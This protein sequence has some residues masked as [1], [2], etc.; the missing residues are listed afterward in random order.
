M[1]SYPLPAA[2]FVQLSPAMSACRASPMFPNPQKG[3]FLPK[4]IKK[5]Q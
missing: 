3:M 4:R 5:W 2:V 1:Q